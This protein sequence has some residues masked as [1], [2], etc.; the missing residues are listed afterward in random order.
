METKNNARVLFLAGLILVQ[1]LACGQNGNNIDIRFLNAHF[2]D[3]T[4]GKDVM[5]VFLVS[6]KDTASFP[7][8]V[9]LPPKC[10]VFENG[11][12]KVILMTPDNLAVSMDGDHIPEKNP[13]VYALIKDQIDLKALT[14]AMIITYTI[15]DINYNFRKMSLTPAFFEKQNKEIRIDKRFEFD[16]K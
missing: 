5:A 7:P 12:E 15:K 16:V 4:S 6:T 2:T 10:T 3:T 11:R 13:L 9:H 8:R 14:K 1:I